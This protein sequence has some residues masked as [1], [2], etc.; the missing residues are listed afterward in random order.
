MLIDFEFGQFIYSYPRSVLLFNV[1]FIIAVFLFKVWDVSGDPLYDMTR[2]NYCKGANGFILTFD[3]CDLD[4]FITAENL[5]K[6][7]DLFG[8]DKAPKL[9][10]GNKVML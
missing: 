3:V 5:L 2:K 8:C 4:S 9:L 6:E 10:I 7:L 1:K